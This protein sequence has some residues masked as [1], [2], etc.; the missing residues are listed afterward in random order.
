MPPRNLVSLLRPKHVVALQK[1]PA[2]AV[3]KKNPAAAVKKMCL[4][5]L[6]TN[7][8]W[9]LKLMIEPPQHNRSHQEA[10]CAAFQKSSIGS[11]EA[12]KDPAAP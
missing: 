6:G 1:K 3:K 2:A 9:F 8:F 11:E 10:S 5:T 4:K 7:M 12:H